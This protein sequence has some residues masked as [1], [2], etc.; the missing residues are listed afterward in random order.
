[1]NSFIKISNAIL[2]AVEMTSDYYMNKRP[3]LYKQA[4]KAFDNIRSPYQYI[5]VIHVLTTA[6]AKTFE[7]PS[8]CKTILGVIIGDYGT[9][10][11]NLFTQGE[12]CIDLPYIETQLQWIGTNAIPVLGPMLAG[13]KYNMFGNVLSFDTTISFTEITILT[14]DVQ[15]DESGEILIPSECMEAI[16]AYLQWVIARI[17][18]NDAIRRGA[19]NYVG[20]NDLKER[21]QEYNRLVMRTRGRLNNLQ[22]QDTNAFMSFFNKL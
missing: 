9:D 2:D 5:P 7:V 17:E 18:L 13:Y 3:W 19:Y 14:L 8:T 15:V 16:S 11:W 21:K 4:E 22:E 6:D 10:C 1:M 12:R 20:A